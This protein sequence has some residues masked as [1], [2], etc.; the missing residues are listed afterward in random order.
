MKS[1]GRE[2]ARGYGEVVIKHEMV[3]DT[4]MEKDI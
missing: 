3:G 1:E 2:E 4:E